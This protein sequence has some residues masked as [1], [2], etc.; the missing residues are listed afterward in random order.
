MFAE[1][2]FAFAHGAAFV[3]DVGARN[4]LATYLALVVSKNTRVF[5]EGLDQ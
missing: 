2:D 5:P 3:S 1:C 4:L